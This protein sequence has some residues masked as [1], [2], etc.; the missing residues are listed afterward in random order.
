[1]FQVSCTP[2]LLG[3]KYLSGISSSHSEESSF[4]LIVVTTTLSHPDTDVYLLITSVGKE[5]I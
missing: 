5:Y 1:M 2:S 3:E 4:Q